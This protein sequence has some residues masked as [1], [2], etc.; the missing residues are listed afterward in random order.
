MNQFPHK[1][2]AI[3]EFKRDM[4]QNKQTMLKTIVGFSNT[5]GGQIVVGVDNSGES[6]GVP[7]NTIDQVIDDLNRSIYD[8]L[9]PSIYPAIY[10]K[11]YGDQLVIVIDIAEGGNKPYHFRDMRIMRVLMFVWVLTPCSQHRILFS[12]QIGIAEENF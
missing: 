9:S 10:T 3:L 11:R 7:E 8:S 6:I 5:Y 1:E 4:P 2:S 12:S